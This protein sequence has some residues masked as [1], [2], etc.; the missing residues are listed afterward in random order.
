MDSVK[1]QGKDWM[2]EWELEKRVQGEERKMEKGGAKGARDIRRV[3]K[4]RSVRRGE[5]QR[6]R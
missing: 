1:E 6:R 4:L 2:R 3:R 5:G